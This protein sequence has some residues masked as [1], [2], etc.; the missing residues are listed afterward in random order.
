[1]NAQGQPT[2]HSTA[3]LT[4]QD[5]SIATHKPLSL[6]PLSEAETAR[7]RDLVSGLI[8]SDD[9]LGEIVRFGSDVQTALAQVSKGMLTGVRVNTLDE[10]M[11][12]S[13]R[14]LTHVQHVDLEC[15]SPTP[16]R[17]WVILRESAAAIRRRVARFFRGFSLVSQQLDRQEA[18]LFRKEADATQ[19]FRAN[20]ELEKAALQV[21]RDARIRLAAIE[22]FLQG[23]Y[24]WIELERRQHA[25]AAEKAA[26]ARDNRSVDLLAL[27]GAERYGKYLDRVEMKRTSLQKVTLA[28]Y[29]SGITLRMLQDNENV[30][31]QKL[32]DVR[33]DL[34]PQWRTLIGIA[35]NAYL[36]QGIA[37]FV[38]GLESAEA[39]VRTQTADQL[40][41]TAT[42]VAG[43]MT[44]QVFDPVSMKYQQ[45]KLIEALE[46][47]KAATAEAR[48]IREAA[49]DS[50]RK[51]LDDLGEAVA[52][53][54][55]EA[56]GPGVSEAER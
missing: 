48:K 24:G 43:M 54:A 40:T 18:E 23:D 9:R 10:V 13:E 51:S 45:D 35:Y 31:R 56:P 17:T 3:T 7:A 21:M 8:P 55:L 50:I 22:F 11:R 39:A 42:A 27:S 30:I 20:A 19:R 44:R 53:V 4:L 6:P 38:N 1:M 41:R 28:A 34:L 32:S 14:V 15:L 5:Y 52:A 36:Q 2:A 37:E 16:R 49:E 26:A 12:L 46:T 33:H 25:V 29:Q 47:L